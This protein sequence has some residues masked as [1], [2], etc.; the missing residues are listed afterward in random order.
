VV[1]FVDL[2]LAVKNSR[3]SGNDV[4]DGDSAVGLVKYKSS[5]IKLGALR[6]ELF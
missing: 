2:A 6:V 5:P 1:Y 3:L 4:G